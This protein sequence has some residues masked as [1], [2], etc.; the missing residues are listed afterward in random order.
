LPS[1]QQ[2][3]VAFDMDGVIIDHSSSVI[4]WANRQGKKLAY[5]QTE[6][7][8]LRKLFPSDELDSLFGYIY[9]DPEAIRTAAL[10]D[11]AKQGLGPNST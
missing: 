5:Q 10:M 7:P 11:G 6:I 8:E 2:I 1:S 9:E 3:K 4:S